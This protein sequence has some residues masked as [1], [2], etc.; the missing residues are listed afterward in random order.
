M[1][2]MDKNT[3]Q[4]EK[5]AKKDNRWK[6]ISKLLRILEV[7]AITGGVIFAL[8][9]IRDVR[10]NQSAQL[11]LEFNRSLSAPANSRLITVIENGGPVLKE[12]GGE[13]TTTDIDQYLTI[14]ELL[15]NVHEAG[16]ITDDM[17]YNAFAYEVVRTYKNQEI[18]TYLEKIRKEDKSF[19]IGFESL[20]KS[21]IKVDN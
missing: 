18:Q 13:F 10:N 3:T 14:Y 6:L 19:F 11:M 5:K 4:N 8:V 12:N 7:I 15:N 17:L 1:K 2:T 16:L 20:A 21:L 9:Q